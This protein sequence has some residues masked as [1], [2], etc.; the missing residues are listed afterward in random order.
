MCLLYNEYLSVTWAIKQKC[1][2]EILSL[3][4]CWFQALGSGDDAPGRTVNNWT[5]C[6]L[7]FASSLRGIIITLPW[8]CK[9]F[10]VVMW[11]C[12]GISQSSRDVVRGTISEKSELRCQSSLWPAIG[13]V[14]KKLV[15]LLPI[16]LPKW[17]CIRALIYG[18]FLCDLL[19]ISRC[20]MYAPGVPNFL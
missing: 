8:P 14:S 19:C 16:L 13:G 15:I 3:I 6:Q 7:C 11:D 4:G 2:K 12:A 10:Q 18:L 9:T 17:Q 20:I 5:S 1:S